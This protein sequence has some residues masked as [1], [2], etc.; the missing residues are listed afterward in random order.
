MKV[1]LLCDRAGVTWE[2]REG[3]I[4][5]MEP[6]EAARLIAAGSAEALN[7]EPELAP[8]GETT[9]KQHRNRRR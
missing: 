5:E 3:D 4:V 2:Q 1:R 7:H 8:Q 6:D 9:H